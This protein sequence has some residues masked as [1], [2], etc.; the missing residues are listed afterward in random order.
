MDIVT[1]FE[2]DAGVGVGLEGKRVVITFRW[3]ID[4]NRV[5]VDPVGRIKFVNSW[6]LDQWPGV[7]H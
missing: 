1:C 2:P 3:E 4:C 5:C 7:E 6:S